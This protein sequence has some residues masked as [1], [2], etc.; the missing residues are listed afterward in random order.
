MKNLYNLIKSLSKEEKRKFNLASKLQKGKKDYY[1]LYEEIGKLKN[2]QSENE[3]VLK[4]RLKRKKIAPNSYSA[5]KDYLFQQ[6]LKTLRSLDEN[7]NI[8][9]QATRLLIDARILER[10]G[11]YDKCL[12]KLGEL[13][14][15]G[16]KYEMHLSVIDGLQMERTLCVLQGVNH[17]ENDLIK[18]RE[19]I[20]KQIALL[21]TENIYRDLSF[22][23]VALYRTGT[24]ARNEEERQR[25][26]NFLDNEYLKN[27]HL[28]TTFMSRVSMHISLA[29][30]SLM[31][32]D[33]QASNI[34]YRNLL[35]TW[36]GHPHF[37]EVYP[38][39]YIIHAS[40]YLIG[41][42]MV[43]DYSAFEKYIDE[44]ENI[45]LKHF[46]GKAEAFQN[47][48]YVR[49]I[50][51]MNYK[52]FEGINDKLPDC[53]DIVSKIEAGLN[54]YG[55]RIVKSRE[56]SFYH[57]ITILFFAFNAYDDALIWINKVLDLVKT[58]QLRNIQLFARLMRLLIYTE[59]GDYLH[60]N[61]AFKA[62]NYHL[63]NGDRQNDFEGV[64][65]KYLKI[66]A[67]GNQPKIQ[68]FKELKHELVT[69]EAD[70]LP[71]YEE[72]I[73]WIDCKLKNRTFYDELRDF[74]NT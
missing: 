33:K 51:F 48:Y 1:T 28:A 44:M 59:R 3:E 20:A 38:L 60:I 26:K 45:S 12:E 18:L 9:E 67:T 42:H 70:G 64:V 71:Y 54:I 2:E 23:I 8:E 73:I 53:Y 24:R 10:R 34:S 65:T 41:C 56:I 47:I 36:L 62:F 72:I 13:K 49:L 55:S 66:Y 30:L 16:Y 27:E 43:K 19:A 29:L 46:H 11:L 50:Y 35:N 52:M 17:V 63:K 58:D 25:I 15:I 74:L 69:Y 39:L 22:Q 5:T 6:L 7:D 68:V 57:S 61:E 32:A 40:N 21:E 4:L 14:E 31:L 37:K